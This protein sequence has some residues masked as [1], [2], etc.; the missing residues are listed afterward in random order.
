MLTEDEFYEEYAQLDQETLVQQ[1]YEKYV[2]TYLYDAIVKFWV[3]N[4][5]GYNYPL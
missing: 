2:H 3:D 5:T 4:W 1:A